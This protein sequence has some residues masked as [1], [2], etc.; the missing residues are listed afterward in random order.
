MTVGN[1]QTNAVIER[2][3]QVTANMVRTF[4]LE[5]TCMD[6]DAPWA[7]TLAAMVFAVHSTYHAALQ[8]APGQLVF[9]RD[10]TFDVKHI[11]N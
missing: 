11:T 6:E 8:A 1:P 2:M 9:G 10:M 3:H 5:D 7:G 4:E